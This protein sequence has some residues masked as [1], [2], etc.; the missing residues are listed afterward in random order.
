MQRKAIG[1]QTKDTQ[2]TKR[3]IQKDKEGQPFFTTT[4]LVNN[5]PIKFIID[6]GS[7]VTLTPK[8]KGN[9]ITSIYPLREEYKDVN[10]NEIKF[11][12]KKM[13]NIVMDGE[14]KNLELL[15][16]TKRTNPLLGLDWLKHLDIKV[17]IEKSTLH[18]Q[19]TRIL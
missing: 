5:R 7:P 4:V 10:N 3:S 6:S 11:E 13:A 17:N 15:I 8:Q 14:L 1:H 2:K 18:I 9:E 12:G 16:T 19:Y